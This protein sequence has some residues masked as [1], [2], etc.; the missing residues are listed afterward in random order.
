MYRKK[1]LL[2]Q[3]ILASS[4]AAFATYTTAAEDDDAIKRAKAFPHAGGDIR[5]FRV[6]VPVDDLPA[7]GYRRF[8]CGQ[9]G[10]PP[11]QRL[12]GWNDYATCP[13]DSE[14]LYEVAFQYDNDDAGESVEGTGVAGH[15]VLISLLLN[16]EGIVDGIRF[17]TDPEASSYNIRRSYILAGIARTRFGWQGFECVDLPRKGGEFELGGVF[18]KERCVKDFGDRTIA[19]EKY[20]YRAPDGKVNKA[21]LEIRRNVD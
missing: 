10:K 8:A 7:L 13:P 2:I 4:L 12:E 6:G 11:V 14:G 9:N 15:P 20:F 5:E 3:L 1:L 21:F 16:S 17:F 18:H 19:I